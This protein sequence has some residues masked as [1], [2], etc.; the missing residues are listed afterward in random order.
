H[1]LLS[2]AG[3]VPI[4]HSQDT[5]GPMARSVADAAAVLGAMV[6]TDP[7]DVATKPSTA[8]GQRDYTKYL[9][10]N[11]LRGARLGIVRKRLFGS[12]PAADQLAEAAIE[13]MKKSG[14]V[15]IDPANIPTLGQF[16]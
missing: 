3:I 5:A 15:I 4:S 10:P 14:A 7:D 6:G 16:D 1:G 9:D 13:D 2:R 11:G 8:R 12:S